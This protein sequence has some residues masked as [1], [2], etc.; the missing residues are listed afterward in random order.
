MTAITLNLPD[1]IVKK[2]NA[3]PDRDE[4]ATEIFAYNLAEVPDE[5]FDKELTDDELGILRE[6]LDEAARGEV[7]SLDEA[8]AYLKEQREA[9]RSIVGEAQR[10]GAVAA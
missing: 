8:R 4:Y 3:M 2:L 7:C 10:T 5:A 9:Q 6:R 1:A